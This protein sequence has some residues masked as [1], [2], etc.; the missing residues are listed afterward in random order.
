MRLVFRLI[1]RIIL[2]ATL[3]AGEG[4]APPMLRAYETGVLATL[5]AIFGYPPRTRT[6]TDAFG[7]HSAAITLVS[8][9]SEGL[10]P[11]ISP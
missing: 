10:L 2:T 8:K 9:I 11:S 7:E 1:L 4:F 5:P 6:L 3:D